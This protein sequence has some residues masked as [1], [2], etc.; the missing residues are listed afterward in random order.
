MPVAPIFDWEQ[1]LLDITIRATIKG[2]KAEAIDVFISD[3]FIKV[4]AAPTYLLTLDLLYPIVVE[5]SSFRIEGTQVKITLPKATEELWDTLCIDKRTYFADIS[6]KSSTNAPLA[7]SGVGGLP[8]EDE[9]ATSNKDAVTSDGTNRPKTLHERR[10]M[11]IARAEQLYNT[12]LDTREK[13]KAIEKKRMHH[14]QWELEKQQRQQIID[15]V[16]KEKQAEQ[17]RLY[18]WEEQ[19]KAKLAAKNLKSPADITM[20][21]SAQNADANSTLPGV[22]NAETTNYTINFTP[23]NLTAPTRSRGDED[24]Y[25][26]SKYRPTCVEDSPMFWKDKADK[27]YR[28]RDFKGA[29]EAY[30]ESIK[31]DGVFLSCVSNRAA[32]H[33]QLH[34]Y[35]KAIDD[36]DLALTLLANTPA[37]DTTQERYKQQMCKLHAR[38]GAAKCWD[39]QYASGVEDL[40][41]AVA[42]RNSEEDMDV[43]TDLATVEDYM[44]RLG[45]VE[46]RDPTATLA[47][48]ASRLYYSGKYEQAADIYRQILSL[49][50]FDVKT[51]NNLTAALLQM[52]RHKEALAESQKVIEFCGEVAA[53]LKEPGAVSGSALNDSDDE[54]EEEDE[55]V[56]RKNAAARKIGEK[57]GHVYILLKA[58]VRSAAALS[59]LKD[60]RRAF[61]FM[62]MAVRITPYDDD[63][64]ED[65]NKLLE[66][67]KFETLIAASSVKGSSV[68]ANSAGGETLERPQD[69][70]QEN[71]APPHA[72]GCC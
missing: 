49:N 18:A 54:D 11:A 27:L 15:K 57:S 21:S 28:V 4:N 72:D 69:S 32:C 35:K 58:Y 48:D 17:E 13:Q 31:R 34:E 50:E 61:E 67:L 70:V 56:A 38:R 42:Y 3:L 62:E 59:G 1:S 66:K 52:G 5:K 10:R 36:C 45:I 23:K 22:R 44:K 25:R 30:T 71:K 47:G 53:A 9:V 19:E 65:A 68:P 46:E 41:M 2:F 60:Y 14:E 7:V 51:R 6:N 33:I 20:L 64:R 39:G 12:K 43:V 26:R 24:Y 37:S 29:A 40:R 8:D 55:L 63:L 16:A